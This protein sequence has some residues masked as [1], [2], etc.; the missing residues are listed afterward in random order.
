MRALCLVVLLAGSLVG[1]D[2]DSTGHAGDM[3][4]GGDDLFFGGVDF[5]GGDLLC[6]YR[7][8]NGFIGVPTSLVVFDCPC[9]CTVDGMESSVVNP[10]WGQSHSPSSS[11]APIVG[12]A[13]GEELHFDGSSGFEFDALY[14]VG[15]TAQFF[16]DGDFDMLVDY[17]LVSP[18]PGETHLVVS[19]RDPGTVMGIQIFDIEREQLA[20]GSNSYVTMLGGVPSNAIATTATHGTLRMTRQGFTYKTYGDGNL[21]SMLIAQKA[22]R[23]AVNVTATLNGCTT[24]DSGATC[25]YQPRFH[26]LR[27][28]SGTLVNLP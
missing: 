3:G 13:L 17:D 22:P 12:T 18:P 15:P 25:S 9:G 19:V 27:L 21:V 26:N 11:F 24:S 1:C 16:L 6:S 14:S 20:D 8:F 7:S 5:A 23:V 28:A 10:M 2:D 4:A